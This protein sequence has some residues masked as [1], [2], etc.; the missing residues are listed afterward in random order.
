MF[1]LK[2]LGSI[3]IQ[4]G[5][6][7]LLTFSQC[8]TGVGVEPSLALPALAASLLQA[9]AVLDTQVRFRRSCIRDLKKDYNWKRERP[10][11]PHRHQPPN[12]RSHRA[13][14]NYHHIIHYPKDGEY[15]IKKLDGKSSS[16]CQSECVLTLVLSYQ[17]GR[18]PP[19]HWQEGH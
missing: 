10:F 19:R 8:Q 17:A 16:V 7:K 15:T 12:R 3:A 4:A 18:S 5:R 13:A 6:S 11:G 9:P 2:S 1:S 14:E